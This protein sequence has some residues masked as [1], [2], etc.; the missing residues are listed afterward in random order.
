MINARVLLC[1]SHFRRILFIT[2]TAHSKERHSPESTS[3]NVVTL[4]HSAQQARTSA[5]SSSVRSCYIVLIRP[6]RATNFR[7]DRARPRPPTRVE[8]C[9]RVSFVTN[10][11]RQEH[12]LLNCNFVVCAA[13]SKPALHPARRARVRSARPPAATRCPPP[14]ARHHPVHRAVALYQARPWI[15]LGAA[16]SSVAAQQERLRLHGQTFRLRARQ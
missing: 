7:A 5:A 8:N 1:N 16:P 6:W 9:A 15:V 4:I 14:A 12:I 3:F 13:P 10:H 11:T 2:F